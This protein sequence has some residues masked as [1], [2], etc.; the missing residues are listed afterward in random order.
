MSA[1]KSVPVSASAAQR[2]LGD[3]R[4][5]SNHWDE[6]VDAAG[7]IR[8]PWRKL[9]EPLLAQSPQEA[10][11][12][13]ELSRRLLKEYG[14]TYN[15]PGNEDERER[16]WQ[17]DSW[18]LVI[19][20]QEWQWISNAVAQRARLL[21]AILADIYGPRR[22][23]HS[24]DLPPEI[25][26][27]NPAF[28]RA[29]V[30][31]P[32]QDSTYLSLYAVDV[33][34]SPDGRWWAVG[35]RTDTP[36][37][38]GYALENRIVL[39]RVY[40]EL[41]RDLRVERLARFF[42]QLR[43]SL[44]R[45]ARRSSEPR[46]VLLTPGPYNA[47]YFEQVYLARYLGFSL[48]EG[49]DLTVRDQ[50]VFLKTLN[51]L[52][53][54]DVI[55]RRLD[56]NFCDPLELKDDSLLGVPGLLQAARAGKIVLANSLG[57]G[58]VET[59]ALLPFLPTL[60]RRLLGEEL[61]LPP[62][63]T[64]WCGQA[65][66]RKEV[67]DGL[68]RLVVKH[69]FRESEVYLPGSHEIDEIKARLHSAP[70]CYVGQEFV[71]LSTAPTW[72]D[73]KLQPRHLML[74]IFVAA[75]GNGEYA[76]MPGGLTRASDSAE[77]V[78]FSAQ[79]GGGSKDTW[80]LSEQAP[81]TTTLLP[82]GSHSAALSRAGFILPSRLADNLFW[83]ARYLERIEFGCR[84][85]RCLLHR[86]TNESEQGPLEKLTCLLDV[87]V[88]HGRLVRPE[89]VWRN[90]SRGTFQAALD[91]ALFDDENPGSIASDIGK[92]CR[93]SASVRDRLSHDAWRI[94]RNLHDDFPR[95]SSDALR[96]EQQLAAMDRVI[97][98]LSAFSGLSMDGMTRDKGWRFLDMGRRLERTADLCDLIRYCMLEPIA[99]EGTRLRALLEVANSAMTYRSRYVFG[100]DPA[101]VLDLLLADETNP[102][103]V[104][105]QLASLYQHVRGLRAQR[106][107]LHKAA[108]QRIVL[109]IFSRLRLID[110]DALAVLTRRGRRTQLR[111]ELRRITRAMEELSRSLTRA[112]LTHLQTARPLGGPSS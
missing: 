46:V 4:G 9:L 107:P 27:A 109:S 33:A 100:P 37:G 77:S 42:S 2:S 98:Q 22:L 8:E 72:Q 111:T 89:P 95:A 74:R 15:S 50:G 7:T 82:S 18:P 31:L 14:V 26:L 62:I 19:S 44:L 43:D 16:P 96:P 86:L 61:L 45:Q 108:E 55:L 106:D 34:R 71:N 102:R 68:E 66:A 97:T 105:F 88:A 11:E 57:V 59:P 81:D 93:I 90:A 30:N 58:A 5:A 87:L 76:V 56:S 73:R 21:N 1:I 52:L 112:Y 79:T 54:V 67:E 41:V 60:S 12:R 24:G 94:V 13:H 29:A 35:D 104:A 23:I 10:Q 69:A 101:P 39:N 40:P 65:E 6:A 92:V 70:H 75:V 85:A 38:A 91:E 53:P 28:L 51:G 83:L 80:V 110:V 3:Y 78:L 48:V 47:T 84:L 17:L 32:P 25:V 103:S 49:S 64:W 20:A 63:A 36:A 99:E